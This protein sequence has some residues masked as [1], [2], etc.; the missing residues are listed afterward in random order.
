MSDNKNGLCGVYKPTGIISASSN[1]VEIIGGAGL[2]FAFKDLS[3]DAKCTY[4]SEQLPFH[5]EVWE[6]SADDFK[7]L[8]DYPDE[9]WKDVWGWWRQGHCVYH[10]NIYND[11]IVNGKMMYG[12]EPNQ[13]E[14]YEAKPYLDFY[15]YLLDVH[16]VSTFYNFCYFAIS[17][18]D[19]N[20][21]KVSEFL[22]EYQP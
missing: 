6:V 16:H 3:M 12:Y 19:D 5:V 9:K 1:T 7:T 17:L 2:E 4:K 20:K 10:G 8:C 11:Y 15:K 18:A 21:M 13:K 22:K 14:D